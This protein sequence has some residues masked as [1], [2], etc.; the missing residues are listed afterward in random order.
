MHVFPVEAREKCGDGCSGYPECGVVVDF[1]ADSMY[2][3]AGVSN[4][5]RDRQ[6]VLAFCVKCVVSSIICFKVCG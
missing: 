4:I 3:E 5:F 1:N 6:A 2:F